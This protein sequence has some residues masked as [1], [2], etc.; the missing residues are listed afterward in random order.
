MDQP[1]ILL[2]PTRVTEDDFADLTRATSARR[3]RRRP[4]RRDLLRPPDPHRP[5]HR[6]RRRSS[7]ASTPRSAEGA[8]TSA[9]RAG[10]SSA[11]CATSAPTPRWRRS[12]PRSRTAT[13]SRRSGST[14][15]RPAT[16]RR[17]SGRLRSRPGRG[18]L[19]SPTPGRR[20][21]PSTSARRSTSSH[22]R[23]IDHGVRCLEDPALVARLVAE[24]VPLTVCPL[25]NVKLAWS[26]DL[27]AHPL[28]TMLERGLCVTVNSDDPAYFGG[29]VGG[30]L[31]A[32][33]PR[34]SALTDDD[35]ASSSPRNSFTASF[36]DDV[37]PR[38]TPRRPRHVRSP[39][40]AGTGADGARS[41]VR[42]DGYR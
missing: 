41:G 14:R 28:R 31:P 12:K 30:E 11:S 9:S 4:P 23:R 38:S 10:S 5:R 32:R 25:S 13:R 24:Q 7:T 15:P 8:G 34:R 40:T 27:A 29:Y 37:E 6:A 42:R 3:R 21:R 16:R 26:P 19:P 17:T 18:F 35:A 2:P 1:H 22:V 20:A 39:L 36:L 33:R